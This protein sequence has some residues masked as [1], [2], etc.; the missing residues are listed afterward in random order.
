MSLSPC[1]TDS[2][3]SRRNWEFFWLHIT[4]PNTTQLETFS[5]CWFFVGWSGEGQ[6]W[7]GVS[8]NLLHRWGTYFHSS[9]GPH[10]PG[11]PCHF[12]FVV[13][14]QCGRNRF[15]KQKGSI[16]SLCYLPNCWVILQISLGSDVGFLRSWLGWLEV[17][18]KYPTPSGWLPISTKV[19]W[20]DCSSY[21]LLLSTA[22]AWFELQSMALGL[23]TP[24]CFR[25]QF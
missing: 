23:F 14:R 10:C 3:F 18:V 8:P 6:G 24:R 13:L 7:S 25:S 15:W 16:S 1:P 19:L 17:I 11:N 5:H 21:R 20:S 22:A 4:A 12:S 9:K 2:I